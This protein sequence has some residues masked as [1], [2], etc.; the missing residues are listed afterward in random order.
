[1]GSTVSAKVKK[2]KKTKEKVEKEKEEIHKNSKWKNEKLKKKKEIRKNNLKMGHRCFSFWNETNWKNWKIKWKREKDEKKKFEREKTKKKKKSW[3]KDERKKIGREKKRVTKEKG[4]KERIRNMKSLLMEENKTIEKRNEKES[5]KAIET[6]KFF[7]FLFILIFFSSESKIDFCTKSQE[8]KKIKFVVN[9]LFK[10]CF[11]SPLIS[12]E[13]L[14]RGAWVSGILD[15]E[16]ATKFRE[17]KMNGK[18]LY[19]CMTNPEK[20]EFFDKTGLPCGSLVDMQAAA[21]SFQPGK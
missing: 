8:N 4:R 3:E 6:R 19:N 21:A 10:V 14:T 9:N 17:Q 1:M 7:F 11:F 13:W 18:A 12:S 15:V 2:K 5:I 16:D 20:F